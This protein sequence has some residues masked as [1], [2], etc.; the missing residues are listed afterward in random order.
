MTSSIFTML[1]LLIVI[2][3]GIVTY[4][5]P[6]YLHDHLGLSATGRVYLSLGLGF[7]TAVLASVPAFFGYVLDLLVQI[8]LDTRE[9]AYNVYEGDIPVPPAGHS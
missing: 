8:E 4:T 3:G 7:G 2:V 5:Y 1:A 6:K 9:T